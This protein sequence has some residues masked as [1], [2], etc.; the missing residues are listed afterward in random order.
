[1]SHSLKAFKSLGGSITQS[2]PTMHKG[3][4]PI[5]GEGCLIRYY[6]G[7]AKIVLKGTPGTV[8]R[9][10]TAQNFWM[11]PEISA[12]DGKRWVH[13]SGWI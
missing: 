5:H 11:W 12:G 3:L 8:F 7:H 4:V 10:V 13:L 2:L 9:H 1:M 6:E